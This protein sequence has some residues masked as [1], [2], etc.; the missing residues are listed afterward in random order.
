LITS[1]PADVAAAQ[2]EVSRQTG[3]DT[4]WCSFPDNPEVMS[5]N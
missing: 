5:E 2:V 4:A 1:G 3:S